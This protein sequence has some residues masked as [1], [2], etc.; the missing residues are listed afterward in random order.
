MVL[1]VDLNVDMGEGIGN[2]VVLFD[3][4]IL[5]NVVCGFYVGGFDVMVVMIV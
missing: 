2:D 3:L 1:S 4:V 5:V